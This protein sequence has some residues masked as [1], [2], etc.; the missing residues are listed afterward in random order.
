MNPVSRLLTAIIAVI[1]LTAAFF[2]GLAVLAVLV[3]AFSVFALIVYLRSWWYRRARKGAEVN[4][5][6]SEPSGTVINAEYTVV[7]RR[8]D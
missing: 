1:M 2:F 3:M 5:P 8:R 4:Q 7:S 6:T